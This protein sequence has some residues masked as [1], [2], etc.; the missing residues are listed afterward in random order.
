MPHQVCCTPSP[1]PQGSPLLTCTSPG[2]TQTQFYLSLCGV[3]GS[4]CTESLSQPS[5]HLWHVWGLILIAISPLL[6]SYPRRSCGFSFALGCG[7]S[8][9]SR[10][11]TV[12]LLLQHLPSCWGFS[13]VAMLKSGFHPFWG[14]KAKVK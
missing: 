12:Q 4:W 2:D 9:P 7:V 5:E 8:P 10:S 13:Q 6:L 3:P 14:S 11:S 1:C